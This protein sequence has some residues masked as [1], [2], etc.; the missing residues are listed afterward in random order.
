M[1]RYLEFE[2]DAGDLHFITI[3]METNEVTVQNIVMISEMDLDCE[4]DIV[5]PKLLQ[6]IVT[7]N[8]IK[9]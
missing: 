4:I 3:G 1:F 5:Q 9:N 7:Q 2:E 8:F 6:A